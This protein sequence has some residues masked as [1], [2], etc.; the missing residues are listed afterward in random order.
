MNDLTLTVTG[1]ELETILN[2]LA[3]RPFIEVTVLI[4][5]LVAQANAKGDPVKVSETGEC[6]EPEPEPPYPFG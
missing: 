3:Q 5:K 1:A 6:P 2:A 4:N